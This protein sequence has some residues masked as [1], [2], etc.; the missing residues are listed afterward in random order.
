MALILLATRIKPP[1]TLSSIAKRLACSCRATR[2]TFSYSKIQAGLHPMV[3]HFKFLKANV[4]SKTAKMTCFPSPSVLHYRGGRKA[5]S[6][7]VYPTMDEFYH[8]L[9]QAYKKVVSVSYSAA[10]CKYCGDERVELRP[11]F[12]MIRGTA[13]DVA[14][15]RRRSRE[16]TRHLCGHDQRRHFRE[17]LRRCA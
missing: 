5:V 4:P 8:D 10:G 3:E 13:G 7:S 9:G 12:V 11:T 2:T 14:V 15:S 6:E 17:E 16:V 1:A